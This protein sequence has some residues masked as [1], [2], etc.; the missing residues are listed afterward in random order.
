MSEAP[1]GINRRSVIKAAAASALA[2][3]AYPAVGQSA[4]RKSGGTAY[5]VI[6]LG[7]GFAGCTASRDLAKAGHRVVVLEARN[8]VGGRTFSTTLGGHTFEF[9]GTWIHWSQPHVWAEITRYGM[10]IIASTGANPNTT[11]LLSEGRLILAPASEIMP[12]LSAAMAKFC[13]IDEQDG[14]SVFPRPHDPF[15]A[16]AIARKYDGLSL[17]DRL[18]ALNLP[19]MDRDLVAAQLAINCHNDPRQGGFLDQLKWWSLG[20][21]EMGRMFD[22]LGVYKIAEGTGALA[23][24]IVEDGGADLRVSTAVRS[25]ARTGTGYTVTT[26]RGEVFTARAVVSTLPLNVLASVEFSPPLAAARIAAAKTANTCAGTKCYIRLRRKVGNWFGQAPY[27]H[28]ISLAWTDSEMDG[29]SLLVAFGPP[30]GMDI[31]DERE[32]EK[33]LRTLLP[34]A[35][36]E[37]VYGY[38]WENDPFSRG[39]WCWYRPNMVTT[40]LR[41]LQ[42]HDGGLFFASGDHANG[43]RGFI[44]GAIESGL[45]AARDVRRHL[46]A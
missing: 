35:E 6:V 9:G 20:D 39:T 21:F 32:V 2:T 26:V 23:K 22:K 45:A 36:V 1:A 28:P 44:D 10:G 16:E 40:S 8:R 42:L 3:A 13:N 41:E 18:D 24:A 15:F 46:A 38:Q 11:A 5:D 29:G 31:T 30:K 33:V 37:A 7:G 12:R 4:E 43:W 19:A 14:R 27:P 25:V 34:E 17:Q